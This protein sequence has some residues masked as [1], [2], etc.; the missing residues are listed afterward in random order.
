MKQNVRSRHETVNERFKNFQVMRYFRHP[1]LVDHSG[2]FR[3]V[4]VITQL[5]IEDGCALFDVEYKE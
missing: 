2:C 3:A 4:A 5:D 1:N